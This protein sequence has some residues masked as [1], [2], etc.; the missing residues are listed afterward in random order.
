[1]MRLK[2]WGRGGERGGKE[3]VKVMKLEVPSLAL[4]QNFEAVWE[5]AG[6]IS[7]NF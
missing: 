4:S 1:M 3:H 2:Y 5:L 6:N 7:E